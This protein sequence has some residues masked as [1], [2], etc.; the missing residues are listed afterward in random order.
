MS[1]WWM[2]D[3]FEARP[4]IALHLGFGMRA[5]TRRARLLIGQ[6]QQ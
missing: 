3:W 4:E 6:G 1:G 2:F 5:Q